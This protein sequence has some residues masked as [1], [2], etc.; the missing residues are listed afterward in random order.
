MSTW[1]THPLFLKQCLAANLV[2]KLDCFTLLARSTF[3][4]FLLDDLLWITNS[5]TAFKLMIRQSN[6]SLK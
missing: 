5:Y 6:I 3:K 4:S 2:W 1:I